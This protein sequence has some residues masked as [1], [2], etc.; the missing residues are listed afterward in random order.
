MYT[1]YTTRAAT[2][3][4]HIVCVCACL[5]MY[6]VTPFSCSLLG[7]CTIYTLWCCTAAAAVAVCCFEW[8]LR[9]FVLSESWMA[10]PFV[11]L[12]ACTELSSCVY[13][14]V[15]GVSCWRAL[16]S[17]PQSL[18]FWNRFGWLVHSS[19]YFPRWPVEVVVIHACGSLY[20]SSCSFFVCT[21]CRGCCCCCRRG[22]CCFIFWLYDSCSSLSLPPLLLAHK[23]T[24]YINIG[25][26]QPNKIG[27]NDFNI[28]SPTLNVVRLICLCFSPINRSTTHIRT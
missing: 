22:C 26:V 17:L 4:T 28:I 25:H 23:L 9:V 16:P 12:S 18:G 10:L 19:F 27:Y 7:L 11:L 24:S 5:C 2:E 21:F 14:K 20:R 15:V 3:T 6:I 8:V 1:L 13:V